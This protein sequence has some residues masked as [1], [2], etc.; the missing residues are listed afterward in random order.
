MKSRHR[1]VV[2]GLAT[3]LA[4]ALSAVPARPGCAPSRIAGSAPAAAD[5]PGQ[6]HQ[7]EGHQRLPAQRPR[8]GHAPRR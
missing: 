6:R 4:A 2:A 5:R 1:P 8:P 3:G 7:A